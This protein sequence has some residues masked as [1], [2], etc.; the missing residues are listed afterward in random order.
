[1]QQAGDVIFTIPVKLARSIDTVPKRISRK[2]HSNKSIHSFLAAQLALDK[3]MQPK[4]WT[5]L[6]P[7]PSDF[8]T[9]PI[10]WPEELQDLLPRQAKDLLDK[11]KA[12]FSG[13]WEVCAKAFPNL[14]REDYLYAWLLVNTRTF[15]HETAKTM[16][17]PWHDRLA[18]L[19]VADLFNHAD[20]GCEVSASSE[21]FIITADRVYNVGDEVYISYGEHS[22]DFL[23][24]EYGFVLEDNQWDKVC[25]DDMILPR[26]NAAQRA[27]LESKGLLG[28]YVLQNENLVCHRTQAA[29][30]LLCC[31]K[32]EE[33]EQASLKKVDEMLLGLL[34]GFLVEI[35]RASERV[36][37]LC[38]GFLSQRAILAHRWN[39]I[40]MLISQTVKFLS[41]QRRTN[42]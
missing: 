39:Q 31:T 17:F 2:A 36:E 16:T 20:N 8:A 35:K 41:S 9:T 6:L 27:E 34:N 11:Q 42:G 15:Y 19:P 5:S 37:T 28:G 30:R 23:L 24:T 4:C 38:V 26:L 14:L 13:H 12:L 21:N 29:I 25:L 32:G 22:N 18:L 3:P 1:M 33:N 7:T 40:A 10:M